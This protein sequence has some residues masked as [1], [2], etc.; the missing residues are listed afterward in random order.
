[1]TYLD[2]LIQECLRDCADDNTTSAIDEVPPLA[3]AQNLL[4]FK[5]TPSQV[6][7]ADIPFVFPNQN[8]LAMEIKAPVLTPGAPMD[9]RKASFNCAE[10]NKMIP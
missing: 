10:C 6:Q 1:M 9:V 4:C 8:H 2:S 5:S 7:L 3:L